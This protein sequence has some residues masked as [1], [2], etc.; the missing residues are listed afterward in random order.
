MQEEIRKLHQEKSDRDI[1][2][3]KLT[4]YIKKLSSND[5]GDNDAEIESELGKIMNTT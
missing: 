5:G 1:K 2:I 3:I 4:A